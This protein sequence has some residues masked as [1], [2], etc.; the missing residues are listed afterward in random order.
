[1]AGLTLSLALA[2]AAAWQMSADI[3]S[4]LAGWLWAAS[5]LVLLLTFIGVEPRT[6]EPSL[7]PG[8]QSDRFWRGVPSIPVR[9]EVVIVGLILLAALALRLYNLENLPAYAGDE[10]ERGLEARR[11]NDGQP[12]NIFGFGWW[13][14]PNLYFYCV[15]W[16]LRLFGDNMTGN[17]LFSVLSGMLIVW[18]AYRTGRL[19][20]G[21]R[22]G[23]LAAAMLAVSPLALQ[24]SRTAGESSPTGA[25]WAIGFYFLFM[26]LKYRR[27]SD[28]VLMGFAWGFSLYFYAAGKLILPVAAFVGLYLLVR[29]RI[30][31]V[32]RYALGF[33]LGILAIGLVFMPNAIFSAKGNWS[34]FTQRAQETSIFTP[35]NQAD[36]F[37]RFELPYDASWANESLSAS[38][39][40]RPLLWGWA[41]LGQI[42]ITAESL[43]NRPDATLFYQ[44]NVHNGTMLQPLWAALTLLGLAYALWE[45]MDPRYAV[46]SIWFWGGLLGAAL[47]TDTPS[48]QRIMGAW[49]AVM[50]FS[51]IVLDRVFAAAWPISPALARRWATLPLVALI[52]YLAVESYQEYFVRYFADYSQYW[53]TYAAFAK[54]L[55]NEYKAYQLSTENGS[56][57][58]YGAVQFP[59]KGIEGTTVF[60]PPDWLPVMDASPKG[61]AFLWDMGSTEYLPLLRHFY[62][63]GKLEPVTDQIGRQY[64]YSYKVSAEQM[65]ATHTAHARYTDAHGKVVVRD[66]P[67]IG[68]LGN[69]RPSLPADIA[70]PVRAEWTGSIVADKPGQY[71]FRIDGEG[72]LELDDNTALDVVGSKRQ[73]QALLLAQGIHPV[74]LSGTL[75]SPEDVLG[76][77][78]TTPAGSGGPIPRNV[79]F[80]DEIG[81]LTNE[82]FATSNPQLLAAPDPTGSITA[83]NRILYP[84]VGVHYA[85]S[86]MGLQ[87]PA[88]VRS[89]GFIE[90]KNTGT[91]TFTLVTNGPAV[92]LIDGEAVTSTAS[93]EIQPA[94]SLGHHDVERRRAYG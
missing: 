90:I 46:V 14:V 26:A 19:L 92:L 7:L 94:Q 31:F 6:Q 87:P 93:Q 36:T 59:A 86:L 39:L 68:T 8:P 63:D 1:M 38:L 91:Y 44:M 61:A 52:A 89:R 71:N 27:W 40:H 37:S 76:V 74:Q 77:I 23:I 34:N 72:K 22:V 12:Y 62:P 16:F 48:I 60:E 35:A 49:P 75:H 9:L 42:R 83:T 41:L 20:W 57:F 50:F 28:W 47:T 30:D 32:K 51:A 18:F 13:S 56:R 70:Y 17:R 64:F 29:W 5:L 67:G 65:A 25:L 45:F 81:S 33:A 4:P 10:G 78:W 54:S 3:T 85:E 73:G 66:E 15:S 43:F 53:N 58:T 55:G 21:Q 2:A 88:T 79:L 82:I 11:I 84:A 24:F 69:R 80:N